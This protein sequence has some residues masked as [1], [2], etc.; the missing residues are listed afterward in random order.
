MSKIERV[1]LDEIIIWV[2]NAIRAVEPQRLE[3]YALVWE[4]LCFKLVQRTGDY[5]PKKIIIESHSGEIW[6]PELYPGT[7]EKVYAKAVLFLIRYGF[8]VS[9]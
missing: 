2:N 4:N 3:S 9:K 5:P 6:N 1:K 7:M 8:T